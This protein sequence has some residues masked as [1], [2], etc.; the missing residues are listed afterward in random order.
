MKFKFAILAMMVL[1]GLLAIRAMAQEHAQGA[2]EK[3]G[4]AHETS[5]E[6]DS[7]PHP[8]LPADA[9]WAGSLMIVVLLGFFLAAAVVGP[10]VRAE[11]PQEIPPAH[12]HDEPPGTSGHHGKSGIPDSHGP[13]QG[14][15]H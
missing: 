5:A 9:R 8:V 1:V 13:G 2:G 4:A 6:P 15:G 14:H 12:S 10:I 3:G 7:S 11:M